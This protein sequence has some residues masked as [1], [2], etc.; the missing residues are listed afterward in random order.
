M[1]G[2]YC[3]SRRRGH[4]RP[5]DKET[6]QAE[7]EAENMIREYPVRPIVGVSALV[8]KDKK[9][10]LVRRAHEPRKSQW[11]LPGGVIELGET[12]R[13]AAI[14]EIRE[15]CSIEIEIQKT[16]DVLD[17]IFRDAQG[18]VQYHYVLV[19]LLARYKSGKLRASS[20]ID[21][22]EW[23]SVSDLERYELPDNQL[24]LVRHASLKI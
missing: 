9:I 21:A 4:P 5:A 6:E 19:V 10:L 24:E 23:V 3:D 8:L 20:D 13:N 1:R 15:E 11:S 7:E 12:I 14:R 16:L 22:A 17:R 18:R 2:C